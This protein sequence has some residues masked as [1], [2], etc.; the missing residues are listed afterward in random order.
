[1][2]IASFLATIALA[3]NISKNALDSPSDMSL[4]VSTADLVSI[5]RMVLAILDV[6]NDPLPKCNILH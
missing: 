1:M 5:D 6:K 2:K 4:A 3:F